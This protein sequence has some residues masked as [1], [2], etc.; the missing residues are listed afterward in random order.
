MKKLLI[1]ILFSVIGTSWCFAQQS[2]I[3][4]QYLF[5]ELAIN[6]AYA[7]HNG[8]LSMTALTR[9]Q[10]LGLEGAPRTQTFSV[11]SP[12]LN[13]KVGVGIQ[14]YHESVGVTDQSGIYG[15]YSYRLQLGEYTLS[16]GL[17]AGA[18]FYKTKYSS[19]L[20]SDPNDPNFNDDIRTTT[21]NFGAGLL[22]HN[23][24]YFLALSMPQLLNGKSL[25][26]NVAQDKPLI[27]YGGYVFRLS[28][29]VVFKPSTLLKFVNGQPVEWNLNASFLLNEVV[30][31]GASFRPAN[32][33]SFIV[34]FQILEQLMIGYAYD[35]TLN[36]LRRVDSG[37][38]EIM[39]NYQFRFSQK[40]VKSPRYF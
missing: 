30:W 17:Q 14:F 1:S 12:I 31:L 25:I 11:H 34:Q 22:F 5:N 23:D 6:P 9:F 28:S 26:E 33:F 39:I 3:Y 19:L 7:G 4:T 13:E 16:M 35:T 18:N 21:P 20:I 24:T 10:S 27:F 38:H 32:A 37:S 15:A 29:F 8:Q 40:N 2:S 36:Q